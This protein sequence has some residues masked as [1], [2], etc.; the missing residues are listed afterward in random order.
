MVS[1]RELKR[2]SGERCAAP[3]CVLRGADGGAWPALGGPQRHRAPLLTP[4]AVR[5]RRSTGAAPMRDALC[6]PMRG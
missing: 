6:C 2:G 4:Q 1:T 3:S 5:V